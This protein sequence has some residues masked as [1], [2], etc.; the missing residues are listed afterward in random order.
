MA[1]EVVRLQK[2]FDGITDGRV[3]NIIRFNYRNFAVWGI[4]ICEY[5][6][7]SKSHKMGTQK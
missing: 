2:G 1:L 5:E 4:L 6:T 7:K 3:K